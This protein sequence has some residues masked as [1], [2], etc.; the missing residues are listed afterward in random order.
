MYKF[1][2]YRVLDVMTREVGTV[3]PDTTLGHAQELFDKHEWN[4]LPVVGKDGALCGLVT[5]LDLLRAFEFHEDYSF[6]PYHQIMD[7]AVRTVMTRDVGTVRPR[8][9]LTRVLHKL[10]DTGRKSLP[11]VDDEHHVVGMVSREDVLRGLRRAVSG[12]TP[13]EPI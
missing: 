4:G 6:P 3:G 12:E 5:A 7:R 11:V 1:L 2:E 9:P 8:T 10:V 13:T